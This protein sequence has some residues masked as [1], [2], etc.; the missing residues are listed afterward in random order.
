MNWFMNKEQVHCMK[1]EN[2]PRVK[3]GIL[4]MFF[5]GLLVLSC[6]EEWDI[7]M[8][9]LA[10]RETLLNQG[11]FEVS[12]NSKLTQKNL[13]EVIIRDID[14]D[15]LVYYRPYYLT[16]ENGGRV[17]VTSSLDT[18]GIK[19]TYLLGISREIKTEKCPEQKLQSGRSYE[20]YVRSGMESAKEI[21]RL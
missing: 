9:I 6:K 5:I 4:K 11:F 19:C 8:K 13:D 17:Y 15:K 3:N 12:Y 21:I 10:D 1:K 2:F 20:I 18:K 7:E 16:S 14:E